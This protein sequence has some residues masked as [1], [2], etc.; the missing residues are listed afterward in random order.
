MRSDKALRPIG[1]EKQS[2]S[3]GK[4]TAPGDRRA[5]APRRVVSTTRGCARRWDNPCTHFSTA[6]GLS[7]FA[8]REETSLSLAASGTRGYV[9]I[10]TASAE[11]LAQ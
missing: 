11:T 6:H 1:S 5:E 8:L 9:G 4:S 7:R 10:E 2:R 3:Y